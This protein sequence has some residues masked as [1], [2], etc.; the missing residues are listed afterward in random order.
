MPRLPRFP[1]YFDR[2][3]ELQEYAETATRLPKASPRTVKR[4]TQDK[5]SDYK[6]KKKRRTDHNATKEQLVDLA[7]WDCFQSRTEGE[8]LEILRHDVKAAIESANKVFPAPIVLAACNLMPVDVAAKVTKC[9]YSDACSKVA[10][11][12]NLLRGL[13]ADY[14]EKEV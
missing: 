4:Y 8:D 11:A 9:R 3:D 14:Q 6:R 1:E 13:L 7:G 2:E 5:W 12:R 10:E